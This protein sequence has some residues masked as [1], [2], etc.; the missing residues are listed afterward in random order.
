MTRQDELAAQLAAQAQNERQTAPP[1]P[2][3]PKLRAP[4]KPLAESDATEEWSGARPRRQ[5]ARR[6]LNVGMPIMLNIHRRLALLAA[7]QG[8]D[9]QDA[10]AE[11]ID[12]WLTAKGY[13]R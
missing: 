13:P 12:Q 6:P 2:A 10:A 5:I 4:R 9:A 7:E 1:T 3:A 11:A 8:I